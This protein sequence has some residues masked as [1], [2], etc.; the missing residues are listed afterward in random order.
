MRQNFIFKCTEKYENLKFL[1]YIEK[2]ANAAK[3]N[4]QHLDFFPCFW[5]V[6]PIVKV[7]KWNKKVDIVFN[8]YGTAHLYRCRK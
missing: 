7:I 1:L 4:N 5:G 3:T 2:T 6:L 8:T